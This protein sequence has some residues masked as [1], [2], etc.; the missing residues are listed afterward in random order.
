MDRRDHVK[1][2][3]SSKG[4]H[5]VQK[6]D[7]SAFPTHYTEQPAVAVHPVRYSV[8]GESGPASKQ[9]EGSKRAAKG[10]KNSP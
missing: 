10:N 9:M 8:T 2:G 4:I 1:Q 6:N 7:F 3:Y 5:N